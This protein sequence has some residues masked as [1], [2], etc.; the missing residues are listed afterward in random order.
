MSVL[1]ASG[2]CNIPKVSLITFFPLLCKNTYTQACIYTHIN[3]HIHALT[4]ITLKLEPFPMDTGNGLW[5]GKRG[6]IR[7]EQ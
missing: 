7:T 4:G 5:R 3:T 2:L 1:L 6:Q